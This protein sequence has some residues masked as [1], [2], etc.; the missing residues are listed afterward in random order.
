MRRQSEH[1]ADYAAALD[2][3]RARD[4]VYRCFK[5][6]RELMD[7]IGRAPHG[8]QAA[9]VGEPP[10]PDEEARRLAAGEP[11]AW[12]LSLAAARE[13]LGAVRRR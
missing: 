2:A 4:L 7:D 6:R 3:L 5:T 11:F 9:Y 1:L 13:A 8:P 10:P 12:R